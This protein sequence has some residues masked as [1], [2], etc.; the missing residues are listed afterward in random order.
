LLV[1]KVG[2][3]KDARPTLPLP[4]G[5]W[6]FDLFAPTLDERPDVCHNAGLM[7]LRDMPKDLAR[8]ER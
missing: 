4:E 8:H 2:L 5:L 7:I 1:P 3:A 6:A